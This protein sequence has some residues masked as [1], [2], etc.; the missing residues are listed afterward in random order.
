M[1]Q[2]GT[3]IFQN[4]QKRRGQTS[5][6]LDFCF[7]ISLQ[8]TILMANVKLVSYSS[9]IKHSICIMNIKIKP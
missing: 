9:D 6:F 7:P 4:K 1:L 2:R 3:K 5:P 8:C